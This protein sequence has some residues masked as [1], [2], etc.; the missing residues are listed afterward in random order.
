MSRY[1]R[2][3]RNPGIEQALQHIREA[4]LLSRELGG[5]DADVK[6]YFF[7]LSASELRPILDEYERQHGK[8]ARDYAEQTIPAWRSGRRKMSGQNAS[9]LYEL[10]PRF[11]PLER[12]YALVESLW[13]H[14]GSRSEFS[15]SVGR[16]TDVEAVRAIVSS[17]VHETVTEYTIPA[18]LERRFE[19]LADGDSRVMQELLNHFLMR[20]REEA[21]EVTD[22][23]VAMLLPLARDDEVMKGF[24]RELKIGGHRVNVFYDPREEDVSSNPGVPRYKAQPD[25]SSVGCIVAVAIVILLIWLASR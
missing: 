15:V 17:H 24:R 9:R 11:M 16:N 7:S 13:E 25:Y 18:N 19:W 2:R 14:L 1:R 3:Y 23:V 6:E 8:A 12:K 22:A 21:I 20:D 5:T 4:K 10:L